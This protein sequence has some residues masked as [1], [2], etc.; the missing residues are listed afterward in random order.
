MNFASDNQAGAHPE[1]IEALARASQGGAA[2]YGDDALSAQAEEAV[3]ACF[4]RDCCV[5]FVTTGT[6]ANALGLST[7]CPPWGAIYCHIGAHIL[8][9]ENTAVELFT[10]SARLV[11]IEGDSGKPDLNTMARR[12]EQATTHGVHNASPAVI[13]LSNVT[14]SGTVYQPEE[15]QAFRA[16][17]DQHHMAL[18][19][20]GARF[21]N[22]LVATGA[23]P[24]D[25]SWR[26]GVDVL[27][28]GL[29]KNGGIAAEAVVFFDDVRAE[30]FAYRR[31]R[32]GQLW[33]KHRF[34]AAQW[35]ALLDNDTWLANARHAN[36]MAQKL[37][38][39]LASVEGVIFPWPVQA[40]ELFPILPPHLRQRL[41]DA[42]VSFYDW[43]GVDG[44]VR[45]V[46]HFATDPDEVDRLLAIV[47]DISSA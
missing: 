31:K 5:F 41:I 26:S 13:S 12:I 40:N 46:T 37:A 19:V 16:L 43:P 24:A 28:F 23:S 4:E 17:A 20:D 9:D 10:G 2:A 21:A 38:S 44:M 7:L 15:L 25:L 42:G 27:S 35:L 14:E 8:N 1:V 11:G 33:S 18:Q 36:A 22:A 45:L 3:A 6:A 29:T 39:G 47:S 32:A 34:L 30:E